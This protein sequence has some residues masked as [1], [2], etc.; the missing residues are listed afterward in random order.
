MRG[1]C[2]TRCAWPPEVGQQRVSVL[3][4]GLV[5]Q[6][7]QNWLPHLRGQAKETRQVGHVVGS[8]REQRALGLAREQDVAAAG[9]ADE[10]LRVGQQ[11]APRRRVE[12][13]RRVR[14]LKEN[15]ALERLANLR[16]LDEKGQPRRQVKR[17]DIHLEL[18]A[19]LLR[20]VWFGL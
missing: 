6:D 3:R 12:Q 10:V 20:M 2:A 17:D 11:V 13:R 16:R 9:R 7:K 8:A 19:A 15:T 4:I 18:L 14:N 1:R 5:E